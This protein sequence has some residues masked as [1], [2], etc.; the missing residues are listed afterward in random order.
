LRFSSA[1]RISLS[2]GLTSNS[3]SVGSETIVTITSG[4]GTVSFS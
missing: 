1:Y 4:T 3:T 2:A